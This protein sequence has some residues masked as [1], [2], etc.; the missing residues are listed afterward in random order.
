M[1]KT[2]PA[3][4]RTRDARKRIAASA[5]NDPV[6]LIYMEAQ[7]RFA[8]RLCHAPSD[9]RAEPEHQLTADSQKGARR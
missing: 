9:A 6:K 7:K 5:G 4:Q 8:A 1:M 3:I 2:D